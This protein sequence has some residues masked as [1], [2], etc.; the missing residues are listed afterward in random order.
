MTTTDEEYVGAEEYDGPAPLFTGDT[1]Q[2]SEDVRETLVTLL[3]RRY[4]SSDRQPKDWRIVQE[5]EAALRTR[6]NDMFLDLVIDPVYEV[7]YK[8]QTISDT[9]S[10]F[11]TLLFD[12]AYN[13]EETILLV[14]LRRIIRSSQQA[15]NDAIFVDRAVLIEEVGNFRPSSATNHVR[16]DR[17]AGNAVDS[18]IK[19]DILLRT[20][21]DDRYRLSPII[22]VLLPV[23]RVQDLA[24]WLR[25]QNGMPEDPVDLTDTDTPDEFGDPTGEHL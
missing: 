25:G 18:L 5:N 8:R 22:E 15:G 2:L 3:K 7:A 12:Q 9:G 11:P 4:I 10:R 14:H 6:V 17:A 1:G 24:A 16:D 13:R 23:E 21:V 19:N 20:D